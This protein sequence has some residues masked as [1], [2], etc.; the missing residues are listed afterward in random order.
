VPTSTDKVNEERKGAMNRVWR[1]YLS[2]HKA[3]K[4]EK[5]ETSGKE[6][7]RRD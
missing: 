4:A 7:T 6:A 3:L 5:L 2:E 1:A